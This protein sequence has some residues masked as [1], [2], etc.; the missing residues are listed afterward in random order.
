MLSLQAF[1]FAAIMIGWL[2]ALP[3]AA[4][5]VAI[6]YAAMTFMFP[7]GIAFAGWDRTGWG[8]RRRLAE[9]WMR[10]RDRRAPL[11]VVALA[12]GYA[13]LGG[14][15]VSWIAHQWCGTAMPAPGE[16]LRWLLVVNALLLAWRLAMRAGATAALYGWREGARAVPRAI[17]GNIVAMLAARRALV[18]YVAMLAGGGT[19]WDKTAHR[20]PGTLPGGG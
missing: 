8:A 12:L 15:A 3:L 6:S 13:A 16:A 20:F 10:L 11:A 9:Y 17:V 19:R 5:Q 1:A 4:H 18:R 14:G 2:G 7:L